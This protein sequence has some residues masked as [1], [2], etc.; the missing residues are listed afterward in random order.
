VVA[1]STANSGVPSVEKVLARTAQLLRVMK[2]SGLPEEALWTMIDDPEYREEVVAV[3]LMKWSEYL[4]S[5]SQADVSSD[6]APIM[7]QRAVHIL[8]KENVYRT[9]QVR[10]CFGWQKVRF[11]H[12]MVY[13]VPFSTA[14][15]QECQGTHLLAAV[16]PLSLAE[17]YAWEPK[18]FRDVDTLGEGYALTQPYSG[19]C[20]CHKTVFSRSIGQTWIGQ[21][22][23]LGGDEFVPSAAD[24][25]QIAILHYR[26]TGEKLFSNIGVRTSD[27][28]ASGLRVLVR[29][30]PD[31]FEIDHIWENSMDSR[32][33]LTAARTPEK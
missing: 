2:E 27:T 3:W 30:G 13:Q 10:D 7:L 19:W 21:Q 20:L 29:F 14:T 33:G 26:R 18:F 22:R 12:P 31:G 1:R 25:V 28:T 11:T 4:D 8:G 16:A 17:L 9:I 24:L 6:D 23:V 32:V 15:L 5:V